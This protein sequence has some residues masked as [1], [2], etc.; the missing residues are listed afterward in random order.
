MSPRPNGALHE[1]PSIAAIAMAIY[2]ISPDDGA[3]GL[4]GSLQLAQRPR[5]S[6]R[7][8]HDPSLSAFLHGVKRQDPPTGVDFDLSACDEEMISKEKTLGKKARN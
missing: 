7:L 4:P 1:D 2:R 5:M 6:L 3:R 8:T